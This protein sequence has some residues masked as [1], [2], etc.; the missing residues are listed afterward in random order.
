MET[1][2]LT[3]ANGFLGSYFLE[4]LLNI[5]YNIVIILRNE[6]NTWRINHLLEKCAS[7]NIDKQPLNIIFEYETIDVIVHTATNYCRHDD[8]SELDL[9]EANILLGIKLAI[10]AQKHSVKLFINTDTFF[11][12]ENSI[13]KHM[14]AYTLSKKHFNEWLLYFSQNSLHIVNMKIHH[15]YGAND[16]EDK[17]VP[18]LKNIIQTDSAKIE[19][20]DGVQLRDFI[21][22][23]DVVNAYLFVLKKSDRKLRYKEY[24]VATGKKTTVRD[25]CEELDKQ[26]RSNSLI[27]SELIFGAKITTSDELM[28]IIND[29]SDLEKLGW[30]AYNSVECGINKMLNKEMLSVR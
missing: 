24:I 8:S 25:F 23:D 29:C 15:I 16:N 6:S 28:D 21:Y 1:I 17:F 20:T 12:T 18:W 11:N 10:A 14:S 22:I 2:L 26:I 13:L 30:K 19:L 4:T 27:N 7:Y 5:G 9:V 3:G